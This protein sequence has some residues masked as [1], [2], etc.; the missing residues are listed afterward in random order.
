MDALFPFLCAAL[1][2]PTGRPELLAWLSSHCSS[3]GAFSDKGKGVDASQ[4][5]PP[6][7]AALTDKAKGTR[8]EASRCLDAFCNAG[9]LSTPEL[10]RAV[11]DLPPTTKRTLAPAIDH[12]RAAIQDHL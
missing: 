9:L 2:K 6:L 4:L 1:H 7:M 3:P 8:G 5:L 10:E 11:Q 12:A